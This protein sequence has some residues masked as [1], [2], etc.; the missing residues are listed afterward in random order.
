[1]YVALIILLVAAS[2]LALTA[3]LCLVVTTIDAYR[4]S[5]IQGVLC[6]LVPVYCLYFLFARSK[7]PARGWLG[8]GLLVCPVAVFV[9]LAGGFVFFAES[10]PV[11]PHVYAII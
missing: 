4:Q 1:M 10:S 6:L 2:L 5:P 9:L 8:L 11:L 3:I 7:H